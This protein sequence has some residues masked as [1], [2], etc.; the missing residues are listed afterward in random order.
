MARRQRDLAVLGDV[1][2]LGQPVERLLDDLHRLVDLGEADRE[3]VVVVADR[4]DR[5]LEVEV[6]VGAVGH[7]LAQ[8]PRVAGGAQQRP[9]D[10]EREQ[11]LLVERAGAAQALE[12]DLVAAQQVART[13]RRGRG[14]TARNS[15]SFGLPAARDVLDHAADL[16]V[17]RV[18]ALAGGELEEVEDRLALAEAVPEH[19]DRAE[20]ERAR[21]EPDEVRHD[22]VE[23]EVDHAQVLGALGDLALEQ[24]LDGAAERHRVEVVGE[25][26]HPL[27]DGDHLPVGLLLGG[28]L[29]PRVDVADDRLAGRAR[30]RPRA[31]RAAAARRG[32]RGGAGRC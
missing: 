30:S 27:D 23:L 13:G 32:S 18:H 29:D 26:V 11:R 19:R 31:S 22:P 15:R 7:R 16:E 24:R 4:A 28:L 12:Q 9:G 5:D 20:V 1:R 10:A 21:P 14:I 25:V 17:A 2:A 3:A 6:L 8:V